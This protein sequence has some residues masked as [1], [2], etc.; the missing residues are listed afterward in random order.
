VKLLGQIVDPGARDVALQAR[1][2][3][4]EEAGQHQSEFIV[5]IEFHAS[6]DAGEGDV[7]LR[8]RTTRVRNAIELGVRGEWTEASWPPN[9]GREGSTASGY[10]V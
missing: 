5:V 10:Q 8:C 3:Q 1:D 6:N 4:L 7:S 2:R 9:R